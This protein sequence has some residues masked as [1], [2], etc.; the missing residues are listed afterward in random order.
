MRPPCA[1]T[2]ARQIARP[3]PTPGV[4]DSRSPREN[5][6]N[7]RSSRPAGKPGPLSATLTSRSGDTARALTVTSLPIGVY[8]AAFSNRLANTRSI[9]TASNATNGRSGASAVRTVWPASAAP[10]DTSAVPTTSSIGCQSRLSR[11][12]PLCNRAMSS[13]LLT[14]AFMRRASAPIARAMSSGRS[15]NGGTAEVRVSARP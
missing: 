1:S 11:T 2:I 7:S 10:T 14:M 5:F 12:A 3:R 6:S 13:R 9:N 4:A 8:L 15:G